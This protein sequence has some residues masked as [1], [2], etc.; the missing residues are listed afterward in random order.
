MKILFV[1]RSV[2][3]YSY[4]DSIIRA[5]YARGYE[6]TLLFDEEWSKGAPRLALDQALQD[7][8][9]LHT[10]WG[11]RRQQERVKIFARRELLTALSYV[12][13]HNQSSFYLERWINY[14]TPSSQIRIR[15][16]LECGWWRRQLIA[17]SMIYRLRYHERRAK[18]TKEVLSHIKNLNPDIVIVSPANMRFA[19]E[20][21]Y[22]KAAKKRGIPTVVSALSWDNLTTKGLFHARPD[23]ILVWNEAQAHEARSIHRFSKRNIHICGAPFFDKWLDAA[24]Y[25]QPREAI[26]AEVGIDPSKPYVLYLGSS[27]NITKNENWVVRKVARSLQEEPLPELKS[28]Q[29]VVR[30]HPANAEIFQKIKKDYEV[31]VWPK[32]GE[33]PESKESAQKFYNLV[34]HSVAVMGVNTSAMVDAVIMGK[35]VYCLLLDEYRKTQQDAL[36]FKTLRDS[37]AFTIISDIPYIREALIRDLKNPAS[38]HEFNADFIKRYIRPKGVKISAGEIC[39]RAIVKI[40]C[41]QPV[42]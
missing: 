17:R 24:A 26:C 32:H 41:G 42:D 15:R 29:V 34:Q 7:M 39:A 10:G 36:H 37:G 21:E 40:A 30:P 31:I 9:N 1:G 28:L 33:L 4:Y 11:L 2:Y 16:L 27:S 8:P 14:L 13:R 38:S 35:K 3:H 18:P 12:L 23:H 25:E 20:T 6:I 22:L 19:E 5:L